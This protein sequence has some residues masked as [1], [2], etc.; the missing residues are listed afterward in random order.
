MGKGCAWQAHLV[1]CRVACGTILAPN[2][3]CSDIGSIN[4]VCSK[5]EPLRPAVSEVAPIQLPSIQAIPS[6]YPLWQG[7]KGP[8]EVNTTPSSRYDQS[9]A[10]RE[11]WSPEVRQRL[12]N[13][14]GRAKDSSRPQD[15]ARV[16]PGFQVR[17]QI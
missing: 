14:G 15:P 1:V 10:P 13:G 8:H 9:Q 4:D 7:K 5:I 11:V 16:V 2:R 17:L 6:G 3:R 12:D